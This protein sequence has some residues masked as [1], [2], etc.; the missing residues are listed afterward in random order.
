VATD[1]VTIT[2]VDCID[3]ME[4]FSPNGDGQ[5]DLWMVTNP[6]CL[7]QARVQVFNRYGG[8][9]YESRDYKNNWN[10]TYNGRPVADGT[11][12]FVITYTLINGKPEYMKGNVTILR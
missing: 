11:Y 8:L 3:P 5:N 4:A 1:D 9:V 7:R 2:V 12:Y 10:G 6:Q